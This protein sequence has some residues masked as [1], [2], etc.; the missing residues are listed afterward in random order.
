MTTLYE[1]VSTSA[2]RG[3]QRDTLPSLNELTQR[4]LRRRS[5]LRGLQT[6]AAE[7]EATADL[8]GIVAIRGTVWG[9]KKSPNAVIGTATVTTAIE[10]SGLDDLASRLA[11]IRR[12]Y[13]GP[14]RE[15]LSETPVI[16]RGQFE[17]P[18]A[19]M[20]L[21]PTTRSRRRS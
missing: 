3:V 18:P 1:P 4:V 7:V 9:V 17:R 10:S 20:D 8:V 14:S 12:E 13:N 2:F 16:G 5:P 19:D 6:A 11:A 21:P 15:R